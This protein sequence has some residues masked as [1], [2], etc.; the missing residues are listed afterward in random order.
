MRSCTR[1]AAEKVKLTDYLRRRVIILRYGCLCKGMLAL[2]TL[3]TIAVAL[4]INTR[5]VKSIILRWKKHGMKFVKDQRACTYTKFSSAQKQLICQQATLKRQL[6]MTLRERVVDLRLRHFINISHTGLR[7]I[8]SRNAITFRRV[9]NH[10]VIK[11]G[12]AE[13]IRLQQKDFAR[14][15][16][17]NSNCRVVYWMDETTVHQQMQKQ[18]TWTGN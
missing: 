7:K 13:E 8:Y 4:G 2:R 11:A 12:R 5:T 17:N 16:I 15:Y 18:R 3:N 10:S 6:T 9:S 1:C 14:Q